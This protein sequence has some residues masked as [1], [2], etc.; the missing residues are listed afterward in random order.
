MTAEPEALATCPCGQ[1]P[2]RLTVWGDN[3]EPKYAYASGYCCGEWHVEFRNNH[4]RIGS[5]ASIALATAAWNHAPRG[6]K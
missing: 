3:E 2:P 1:V 4:E 6:G 5:P